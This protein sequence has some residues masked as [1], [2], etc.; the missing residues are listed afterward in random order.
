MARISLLPV[1]FE[2]ES[3]ALDPAFMPGFSSDQVRLKQEYLY[4]TVFSGSILPSPAQMALLRCA[5][6]GEG[7]PF[8]VTCQFS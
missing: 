2:E 1:N 6:D 7:P 3:A 8:T 5:T 4:S